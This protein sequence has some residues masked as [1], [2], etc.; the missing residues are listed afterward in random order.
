MITSI[1]LKELA[2]RLNGRL[3]GPADLKI[4]GV[5]DLAQAT[6]DQISFIGHKKYLPMLAESKACAI[7]ASPDIPIDRPA[8]ILDK[9]TLAF[10]K[11]LDIFAPPQPK[12]DVGIHPAAVVKSQL[13]KSI[14]VG[15][16]AYIDEN[17]SIGANTIIHPNVYIGP[18][19]CIGRNCL[20]W[21]GVVVR[22]RVVIGDRV[23]IHPNAVIGADG[24]GYNFIDGKHCKVTHIGTVMIGDDV[25]IGACACIDRA[26]AGET[27]V[28]TGTKIDNLVQ[29]GHNVK[30]GEHTIL[31]AQVGI[32]GSTKIGRYAV[33]AGKAG[34]VDN[35]TIGD[36]VT[37]GVCSVA[38]KSIPSDS[39]KVYTGVPAQD[40]ADYLRQQALIRRLPE[41]QKTIMDLTKRIHELEQ[42]IHNSERSGDRG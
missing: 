13:D 34:A 29:L 26:K 4:C 6:P 10:A 28:G 12:V 30:V 5:N 32:A 11:M 18:D 24:F 38:T 14:A 2:Q 23:I 7:V 1:T 42:T 36:G 39:G 9:P 17:V 37:L 3:E 21:P 40:N 41:L 22:E 8:I 31:V 19:V 20:I 16:N 15:A 27:I 35:V 33:F 25:E